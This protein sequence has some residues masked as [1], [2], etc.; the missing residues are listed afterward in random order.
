MTTDRI[1]LKFY[2]RNIKNTLKN[3]KNQYFDI[4]AVP[5]D[6]RQSFKTLATPSKLTHIFNYSC[7]ILKAL[8]VPQDPRQYLKTLATPSRL[9]YIFNY[10]CAIL[11]PL[12]D[13]QH[14]CQSLNT[15]ATPSRLTHIFNY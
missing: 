12:T 3:L 1:P 15:L 4:F 11:N 13:T 14:S 9:T 2:K 7:T 10:S 8:V 6:R 5:Q